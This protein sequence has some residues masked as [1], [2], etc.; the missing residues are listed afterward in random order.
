MSL[1]GDPVLGALFSR[2]YPGDADYYW[3]EGMG[4]VKETHV[5]T[6]TGAIILDK[7]MTSSSGL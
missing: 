4:L 6:G 2:D 7:E 3:V 1:T 5:D